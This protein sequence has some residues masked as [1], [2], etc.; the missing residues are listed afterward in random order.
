MIS[1]QRKEEIMRIITE[2]KAVTVVEMAKHLNVSHETIRRDFSALEAEG[3]IEK[4]YGG[5]SLRRRV[6]T[7]VSQAEKMTFLVDEKR[8]IAK[9][10]VGHILHNDCVFMDHSTTVLTMCDFLG[11]IPVTVITNSLQ[12]LN[13]LLNKPNVTAYCIGGVLRANTQAFWGTET[14]YYVMNHF[15]D[16]AF[17]SCRCLDIQRGIY[18][19][20]EDAAAI[21]R[22]VIANSNESFLL[23]DHN[24]LGR[25]AFS[26][27]GDLDEIQ[28]FITDRALSGEWK[29]C[30]AAKNVRVI[31]DDA[32]TA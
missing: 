1:A 27:V 25:A 4:S 26:R 31:A 16:K 13:K 24:K 15:F 14:A 23:A 30:F 8:R 21:H 18:D 6:N 7:Q 3:L 20:D 12:V 32:V 10:A 29:S 28:Y 9:A 19:S 17:F 2:R 5:A 22:Y 11:D